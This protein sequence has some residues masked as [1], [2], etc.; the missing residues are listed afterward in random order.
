VA[1][2]VLKNLSL[3]AA[4]T[5]ANF[6]YTSA[7]VDPV[8]TD[9]AYVLT[10]PPGKGQWLPNCPRHHLFAE[11]VYSFRKG[12]K[13]VAG[14]EYQSKWAIYTDEK[15]YNGELDPAVYRNWQDGFNLYNAQISY[16]W[17]MG[18]FLGECSLSVRNLTGET[19]MAFTEPDPDG[20]SYQPGPGREFFGSLRIRF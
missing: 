11:V 9:T 1:Y 15:A 4:Y 20:N 19:Y 17:K 6:T 18:S 12:F 13:L 14:T 3:H 16:H 5:Y 2:D 10:T 7:T 8:Y